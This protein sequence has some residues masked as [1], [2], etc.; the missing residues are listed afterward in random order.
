MRSLLIECVLISLAVFMPYA[1]TARAADLKITVK[2]TQHSLNGDRTSQTTYYL[3][4]DRKRREDVPGPRLADI[5]DC[6]TGHEYSLDLD[7][8][9]YTEFIPG[10]LT[11]DE[12]RA[13]VEAATPKSGAEQQPTSRVEV[14]T[15]DTGERQNFFGYSARHVITTK[16]YFLREERPRAEVISD[17]WYVDLPVATECPITHFTPTN[18]QQALELRKHGLSQYRRIGTLETGYPVKLKTTEHIH[19]RRPD[20]STH[21]STQMTHELE[22]IEMSDQPLPG[23]LFVVPAGFK[24][25][26]RSVRN[27][28]IPAELLQVS[29]EEP[30]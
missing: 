14:E 7:A 29:T 28:P 15:R 17:G 8:R 16:K 30:K 18:V 2:S 12:L 22:V 4:A 9:K 1:V 21:D 26:G 24:R 23:S 11:L 6:R 3:T 27:S 5:Q 13:K 10:K 19:V 20:G 25:V